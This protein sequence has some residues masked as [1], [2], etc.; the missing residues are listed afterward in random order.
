[1]MSCAREEDSTGRTRCTSRTHS[2]PTDPT[3]VQGRGRGR[4]RFLIARAAADLI[5]ERIREGGPT[6]LDG[7]A[8]KVLSGDLGP[9]DAARQLLSKQGLS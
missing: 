1:M 2:Q 5:A 4:A 3:A 6:A 8:D 7:L 9:A